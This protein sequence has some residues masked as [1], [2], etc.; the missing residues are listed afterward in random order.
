MGCWEPFLE[1]FSFSPVQLEDHKSKMSSLSLN[2]DSPINMNMTEKLIENIQES[3]KSWKICHEDYKQFEKDWARAA[4]QGLTTEA[5]DSILEAEL[6]QLSSSLLEEDNPYSPRLSVVDQRLRLTLRKHQ[7]K[8]EA[9]DGAQAPASGDNDPQKS[10]EK[11]GGEHG[12]PDLD[13]I[14]PYFIVNKTDLTIVAHRL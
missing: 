10:A 2:F 9:A 1:K 3:Y 4:S 7:S 6:L 13:M 11:T 14:T 5:T 12:R 8:G